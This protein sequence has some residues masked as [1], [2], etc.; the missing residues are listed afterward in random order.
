MN[1]TLSN[2]SRERVQRL[3][4]KN[5]ELEIKRRKAAQ[6]KF[7]S[8][9]TAWQQIRENYESILLEDHT[10]SEKHDIEYVLWQLHYK[11]IEDLRAHL[12]VAQNAKNPDRITK[13]R[14][15][16]KTFLSEA[17]GFY[18]DLMVKIRAKYGLSLGYMLD[19]SE[20]GGD[21]SIDVKKG[22]ISCHR[23]FIYLGDLARYKGLYGEGDLKPRDFDAA[24]SYYK[25]AATLWPSS[26]N[27]HHQ[28]A[29]LASYSGDEL[30]AV[31]R[32]FR[33]LAVDTPFTTARDNLII[34]FEKNRQSYCHLLEDS[35]PAPAKKLPAR[36]NWKGRNKGEMRAS[37]KDRKI[38]PN[39]LMEKEPT[40][41]ETLKAFSIR[42]VRLNG[43]LFTR[44]SLE[45]FE[46]VFSVARNGFL[47]LL[48]S[49]QDEVYSFGSDI[50]MCALFITRFVAIM[51]FT[52]YN[53]NKETENQSYTEILQRSVV[54][55]NAFTAIFDFMALIVDRC[56]QLNHPSGSFLLPGIMIFVEWLACCEGI[57]VT[58]DIEEKQAA[59]RS[60]FWNNFVSFLNKMML[61]SGSD[62]SEDET[63]FFNM[64]RYDECE[65][66]NRLALPEDIELRGFLP[67][68]PAHLILDFPTT[69]HFESDGS[70]EKNARVQRIIAAGKALAANIR[71][72]QEKIYFD[73]KSNRFFYGVE[74]HNVSDVQNI[75]M[76]GQ[77]INEEG[78]DEDEVIVFKP[79]MPE[80][81]NDEFSSK[82]MSSEGIMVDGSNSL[83]SHGGFPVEPPASSNNGNAQY[84]QFAQ[85]TTSKWMM[86]GEEFIEDGFSNLSLSG[87][88]FPTRPER[89]INSGIHKSGS[90]Q[91]PATMIPSKFDSVMTP[92]SN[93]D[94]VSSNTKFHKSPVSRPVRHIGPPPGFNAVAPKRAVENSALD[95]YSWL[96][97]YQLPYAAY[98]DG[99]G[100]LPQPNKLLN[101]NKT[102]SG[103]ECFPF[104]GKQV[105]TV[106]GDIGIGNGWL[107][108]QI[109]DHSSLYQEAVKKGNEQFIAVPQQYQGQS[110]WEGRFFV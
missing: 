26:G 17:T 18:H 7:P 6:A 22:L 63:C 19:D 29:I 53:A 35:K 87:N 94:S 36:V 105:S 47:Q 16:F 73:S 83:M 40:V 64:S 84:L 46:E 12:T 30:L 86:R 21:K 13:I 52:V 79:S 41:P 96:D 34:A 55:Q 98:S 76:T 67:L 25:Q 65:T 37:L 110:L 31:Y 50:N 78:E 60:L 20:N 85:P 5:A 15:Q 38:E 77:E 101:T 89:D 106:S 91:D 68:V 74:S 90:F 54:L 66:A 51:I 23:S 72:G 107:D 33:S 11:R 45:T 48:S 108:Y 75:N 39:N 93:S 69:Y 32:Y 28:L 4:N 99:F 100:N 3:F 97:G 103:M 59:S 61:L 14:S 88:G 56:F 102:S 1:N 43:I 92:V 8:D 10:F 24:S 62:E 27:P 44:T 95:D 58:N 109:P 2:P 9:P 49:G 70:K 42:F 104:P 82:L 80:R 81:H 71:V 57:L